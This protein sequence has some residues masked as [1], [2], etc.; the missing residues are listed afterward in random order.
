MAAKERGRVESKARAGG[1]VAAGTTREGRGGRLRVAWR[2]DS[3][4][5]L[6]LTPNSNAATGEVARQVAWGTEQAC[7]RTHP[8]SHLAI[9]APR[10]CA[11]LTPRQWL[12][13]H[14]GLCRFGIGFVVPRQH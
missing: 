10:T 13:Y 3:D 8:P 6:S 1:V 14:L 7:A 11:H 9:Y 5:V 4:E 2:R 12:L